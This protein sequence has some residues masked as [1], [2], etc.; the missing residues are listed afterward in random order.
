MDKNKTKKHLFHGSGEAVSCAVCISSV[1]LF[2]AA[3]A[4]LLALSVVAGT[5]LYIVTRVMLKGGTVA[6]LS[7]TLL[8]S[9]TAL[10][11]SNTASAFL[12]LAG[13]PEG[14]LSAC[15][16]AATLILCRT[17]CDGQAGST[18]GG[19]F[20]YFVAVALAGAFA[21]ALGA[22]Q[23]FGVRLPMTDGALAAVFSTPAGGMMICAVT[24]AACR[25]IMKKGRVK[26]S[27]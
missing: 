24:A 20:V 4:T 19:A 16:V 13:L 9:S 10:A 17:Y 3:A 25:Y 27:E 14:V 26:M 6:E 12:G 15:A 11:V 2:G 7:G 18:A 23:V 8:S 22:G 1:A 21:E 5:V